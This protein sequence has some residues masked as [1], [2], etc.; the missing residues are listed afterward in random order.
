M[1]E[2]L[3]ISGLLLF[4]ALK[5][6]LAPATVLI[7]GYDIYQTI[8]ITSVGGVMGFITFYLFGS[9]MYTK[10]Q[11]VFPPK[12]KKIFTPRKRKMVKYKKKYGFWG[13]AILTPVLFGIPLGSLIAAAFFP[14]RPKTIAVFVSS[15]IIWSV[16]ISLQCAYL[17]TVW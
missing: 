4:S 3:K 2:I 12:R 17:K 10:Y 16:L 6:F 15:I 13:L 5:F 11:Q 8:L 1:T 9:V 14:E 7:S